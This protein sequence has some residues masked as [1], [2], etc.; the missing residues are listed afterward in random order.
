MAVQA[1][2]AVEPPEWTLSNAR[3][4]V[5]TETAV[6]AVFGRRRTALDPS[7]PNRS[8]RLADKLDLPLRN[9]ARFQHIC[10]ELTSDNI[11]AEVFGRFASTFEDVRK[12]GT[13]DAPARCQL[14][15]AS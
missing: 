5:L 2:R 14:T 7:L 1:R 11:P 3:A 15:R 13:I 10:G 4:P 6:C 12:V 8:N 9:C